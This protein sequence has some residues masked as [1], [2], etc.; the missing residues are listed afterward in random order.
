VRPEAGP[1][2]VEITDIG[3]AGDGVAVRGGA[4]VYVPFTLPGEKAR[5]RLTAAA[6]GVMRGEV[7]ELLVASPLR[8]AGACRHF[9]T[10]GGCAVQ[11]VPGTGYAIWKRGRVV[12]ALARRGLEAPVAALV[13]CL[14]GARR[15]ATLAA[16]RV[17][18]DVVLGFNAVR[19]HRIVA[20]AECPVLDPDLMA[21]LPALRRELASLLT[22]GEKAKVGVTA[23]ETGIDIVLA[24]DR[25][26]AL[27][28]R[29][30]LAAFCEAVDAARIAW[31]V[32]DETPETLVARRPPRVTFGAAAVNPPP[33][34]FLQATRAG[35]AAILGAVSAAMA[36][37]SPIADLY[38]G[39]G[40]ITFALAANGAAVHAVEG[41]AASV[42]A[43]RRAGAPFSGRIGAEC[44]DLAQRPLT[45]D[46][47]DRF[48]AVVFDPPRAGAAAQAAMLAQSRVPVVVGVSCNPATFAR[49]ARILADG[50]YVLEKV[51]PID[52]FLWSPH[53]ELAGVFRRQSA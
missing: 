46:E 31:Q 16:R 45:P 29:E 4:P 30:R 26:P 44:R 34:A 41:D 20:I 53:V 42:A 35:E 48:A 5:V 6:A 27:A 19:S 47:L 7:E 25:R 21:L 9:G 22:T 3:A 17:G 18:D 32:G 24:L 50:G 2:V 37:C 11:H 23:T 51:T 52:Q 1:V 39:C 33:G 13:A 49:D 12:E 36:G 40:T 43:I 28:D 8:Q 15:R 10:C 38:A 14:R